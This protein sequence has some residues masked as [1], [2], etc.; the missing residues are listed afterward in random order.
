[1]GSSLGPTLAHIFVGCLESKITEDLSLQ[2]IC[3]R[4]V[5]D[6]SVISK[7][8]NENEAIFEKLN[9]LHEKVCLQEK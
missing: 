2:V 5:D 8:M 7:T 1:M 9:S 3:I 4:Y 6:F